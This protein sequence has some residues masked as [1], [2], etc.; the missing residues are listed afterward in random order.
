[1]A[2]KIIVVFDGHCGICDG[3]RVLL[4]KMDWL[5][6]FDCRSNQESSTYEAYPQLSR[7][8]CERELK[9]I[10]G[11]K[12]LSG[13]DAM[14]RVWQ[15]TPL[16]MP[17]GWLLAFPPLK[18][19]ARLLYPYLANNRYRISKVCGLKNRAHA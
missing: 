18:W 15:K 14:I 9:V 16:S 19:I 2:A 7:E 17:F 10:E 6:A 3:G 11:S 8:E 12:I 1:M 13:A 4:E 5:H